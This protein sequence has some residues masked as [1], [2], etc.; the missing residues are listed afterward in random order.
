MSARVSRRAVLAFSV[1]LLACK[2]KA[3][4]D[5]SAVSRRA[6]RVVSLS[7]STTEAVCAVGAT[8]QLVGRSRFCDYPPE[9]AGLPEIGGYVDPNLEAIVALS[10]DLVVGARGPAGA[11]IATQLEERGI[12]TFLP[13]TET[14]AEVDSMIRGIGKELDRAEAA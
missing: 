11:A 4:K 7:P 10:P 3:K 12:A 2:A 13:R 5:P 1:S 8:A 9:V 6:R 14:L